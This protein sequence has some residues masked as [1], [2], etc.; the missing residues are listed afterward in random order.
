MIAMWMMQVAVNQI[1]GV[2]AV[3]NCR[4]AAVGPVL[5]AAFV[6]AAIVL[7]SAALRVGAGHVEAVFLNFLALR[8][9]QMAVVEV[10]DVAIVND[11]G[12]AAIRAVFVSVAVMK[13]RHVNRLLLG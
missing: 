2:V 6:F 5:V 13:I 10:I 9:V 12:V 8:M 3:R 4:V 1:I 7:G 11:A